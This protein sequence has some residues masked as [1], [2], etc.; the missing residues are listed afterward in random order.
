VLIDWHRAYQEQCQGREHDGELFGRYDRCLAAEPENSAL[1][2][3][4]GR[5]DEDDGKAADYYERSRLADPQNPYPWY[6]QGYRLRVNGDFAGARAALEEACRLR[7]DD[8]MMAQSLIDVRFALGEFD[9]LERELRSQLEKTPLNSGLQRE[10]LETLVAAGKDDQATAA[11]EAYA[12]RASQPP[13]DVLQLALKS[14]MHLDYLRGRFD[15]FLAG[16]RQMRDAPAAAE[17]HFEAAL[18]LGQ[19]ENLAAPAGAIRSSQRGMQELLLSFA[20]SDR[21]DQDRA[22]AARE[23]A[24]AALAAGNRGERQ[25]AARLQQGPT[26]VAG[27]AERLT[28][29]PEAKAVVLIALARVCPDQKASLLALA[30]KLNY[31]REYPYHFVNRQLTALRGE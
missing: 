1:L 11:H 14:K 5:I 25:A 8:P 9:E 26:L 4:R 6:A 23:R 20:W 28:L 31:R 24:V 3:L 19:L 22:A 16:S 12:R 21:Q 13:G 18:E 15:D 17:T 10:L 7:P 2:Y 29:E 27:S 30:G